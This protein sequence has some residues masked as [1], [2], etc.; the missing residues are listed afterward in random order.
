MYYRGAQAAIVVYDITNPVGS[1]LLAYRYCVGK[2]TD[3]VGGR[4]RL[5]VPRP[6]CRSCKWKAIPMSSLLWLPTRR[7]VEGRGQGVSHVHAHMQV[8][9]LRDRIWRRIVM[10]LKRKAKR[11]PRNQAWCLWS[12]RPRM[13]RTSRSSLTM[14]VRVPP[15]L[16][17][18][19]THGLFT[20]GDDSQEN[21]HHLQGGR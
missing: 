15:L 21:A 19:M 4:V 13:D 16:S 6:G 3:R 12:A 14:W 20:V 5:N 11:T 10:C 8:L 18:L 17:P 9:A 2:I 7:C 1:S